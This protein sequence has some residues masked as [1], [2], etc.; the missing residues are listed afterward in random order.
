M[1]NARKEMDK[2]K[3]YTE[4]T[5]DQLEKKIPELAKV[6]TR[7]ARANAVQRGCSL[8]QAIGGKLY[9]IFPDGT[10]KIIKKI[11][12]NRR[13]ALNRTFHLKLK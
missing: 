7:E 10:R 8:M 11:E 5:L 1:K 4:K 6:A 3:I 13:V 12:P 2:K 9:E